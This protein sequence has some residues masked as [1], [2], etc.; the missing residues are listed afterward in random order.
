M[1][2]SDVIRG[3]NDTFIPFVTTK[4]RKEPMENIKETRCTPPSQGLRTVIEFFSGDETT[5]SAGGH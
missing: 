5:E 3:Y 1:I 2:S 4:H